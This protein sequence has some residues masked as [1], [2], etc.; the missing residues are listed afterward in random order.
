[1]GT[2]DIVVFVF[3]DISGLTPWTPPSVTVA[4]VSTSLIGTVT[5]SSSV[6]I[7]VYVASGISSSTGNIVI[8]ASVMNDMAVAGGLI[9]GE[10]VISGTVSGT[11]NLISGDPQQATGSVPSGGIGIAFIGAVPGATSFN[12]TSWTAGATGTWAR[13]ATMESFDASTAA[14]AGAS[15]TSSGSVTA[16][17]TGTNAWAFSTGGIVVATFSG[18]NVT[19]AALASIAIPRK[20]FLPPKKKF[21]QR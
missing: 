16:S 14:C 15:T 12:P 8:S 2:G 17:A 7:S 13:S 20:I 5:D 1:L 11:N 4:G 10:S 6:S 3:N 18:A 21:Y 9:T 19:P